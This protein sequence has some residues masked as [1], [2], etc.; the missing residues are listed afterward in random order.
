MDHSN[1][2]IDIYS[3]SS[4]DTGWLLASHWSILQVSTF[5]SLMNRKK[6]ETLTKISSYQILSFMQE[7]RTKFIMKLRVENNAF[8]LQTTTPGQKGVTVQS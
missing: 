2:N 1:I 4:T 6:A 7:K 8:N 3:R 5:Q